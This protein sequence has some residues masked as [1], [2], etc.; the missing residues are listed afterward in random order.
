MLDMHWADDLT[1]A[2][3][4]AFLAL[5]TAYLTPP[6]APMQRRLVA[7]RRSMYDLTRAA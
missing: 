1:A 5:V 4:A 2:L 7:V 3:S 6:A